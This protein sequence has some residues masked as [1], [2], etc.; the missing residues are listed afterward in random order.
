MFYDIF[1]AQIDDG[2]VSANERVTTESSLVDFIFLGDYNDLTIS[3]SLVFGIWTDRRHQ[4]S[5]FA[6]EDNTF[7]AEVD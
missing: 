7:G 6:F 5:I 4:V 2:E 1:R 3:D